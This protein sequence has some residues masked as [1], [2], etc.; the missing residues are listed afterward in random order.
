MGRA[1]ILLLGFLLST[2]WAIT[3]ST[4]GL[5]VSC[6]QIQE[7]KSNTSLLLQLDPSMG[8]IEANGFLE[9]D[10][11]VLIE[12]RDQAR[13]HILLE[14]KFHESI[15]HDFFSGKDP[16][17][18]SYN[19]QLP[20][21][22]YRVEVDIYDRKSQ[23]NYLR[24][25]DF[26]ASIP[27]T[28]PW[29]SD[30]LLLQERDGALDP[31]P[32]VGQS[33]GGITD[34]LR[35]RTDISSPGDEVLTARAILYRQEDPP[36][37]QDDRERMQIS[38]YTST[39]QMNEIIPLQ[40]GQAT[41]SGGIDLDEL[42]KGSYLLEIFV[43]RDDS[44]L[45]E[46]NTS[47]VLPW[48]RLKE[49]FLNLNA[50]ID[51]MVYIAPPA[52]IDRLK[53]IKDQGEQVGQFMAFWKERATPSQEEAEAPL[54]RY[55]SRIFYVN[56]YF[57]EPDLEGW[58]TDR[59]RIFILYGSPDDQFNRVWDENIYEVWSYEDTGLKFAFKSEDKQWMQILPPPPLVRSYQ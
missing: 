26:T 33:I 13:G 39:F 7:P 56:N 21:G 48:K 49:V 30:I 1:V 50:S 6:L 29:A 57:E 10:L 54:E 24:S 53:G 47:F 42:D 25:L 36:P 45:V 11:D 14:K 5:E 55:F 22:D 31:Q 12:F 16:F 15:Q 17:F 32:L 58:K 18:R 41:F 44:L 51:K 20:P 4:E 19:F 28:Q 27:G 38:Q 52:T 3:Q 46:Q 37:G 8:A 9:T 2:S 34:R 43:Y 23:R 35:F 59:G 40:A